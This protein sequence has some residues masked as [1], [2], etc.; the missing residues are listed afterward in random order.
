M[1]AT[2][3]PV[4]HPTAVVFWSAQRG[5][6][7]AGVCREYPCKAGTIS[8]T[9]D[10]GRTFRVVLRTRAPVERLETAGPNGAVAVA[11]GTTLRTTDGGRT[12]K[13][14]SIPYA[15]SFANARAGLGVRA[16]GEEPV[17]LVATAD[18]GKTW[19]RRTSPCRSDL[20]TNALVDLVTPARGWAVCLSQPAAGSQG[21][22]VFRTVDGG[23][24][25]EAG[26]ATPFGQGGHGGIGGYGYPKGI[27]FAANGF[28]LLW[29]SRG[30]LYVTRDG[31]DTWTAEPELVRPEADFGRGAAAFTGGDGF[32][33]VGYGGTSQARLL[34][35]HDAGRTWRVVHRWR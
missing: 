26:A 19:P 10:G 17:A 31:G 16:P 23:R 5:L 30:T 34:A 9:T 3:P 29:E 4:T 28:G 8:L 24:H 15:T 7:G 12:W 35:T 27:A 20:A 25:W 6:L 13:A 11:G 33:L 18:G 22:A 21:K 2:P 32:V 14:A 1:I